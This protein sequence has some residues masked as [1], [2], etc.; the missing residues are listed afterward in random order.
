M[1][2]EITQI[3]YNYL[4]E[5]AGLFIEM[6][7][8]L[9]LGFLFAGILYIFMPKEMLENESLRQEWQKNITQAQNELCWEKEEVKLLEVYERAM[10]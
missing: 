8:Y 4:S 5:V 9:L 3:I 2:T 1:L 6:A 7:P 10:L